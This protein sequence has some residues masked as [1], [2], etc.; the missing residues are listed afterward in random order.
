MEPAQVDGGSGK[1]RSL[2]HPPSLLSSAHRTPDLSLG[3]G[4]K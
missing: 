3:G 2:P 4:A 1:F